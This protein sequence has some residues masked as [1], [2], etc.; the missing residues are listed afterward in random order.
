MAKT[1]R[2]KTSRR[3]I[4]SKRTASL[5]LLGCCI[6]A[7]I[8][9]TAIPNGWERTYALFGLTDVGDK[10]DDAPFSFHVLNVGKADAML[11]CCEGSTM[12]VDCD[13]SD[14]GEDIA[15]YLQ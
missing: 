7:A 13:M 1:D 2:K 15:R 9:L 6:A 8:A 11:L 4:P 14:D 3:K 12:L 10:A 5:I